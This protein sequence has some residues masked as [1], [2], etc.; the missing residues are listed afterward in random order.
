MYQESGTEPQ[1]GEQFLKIALPADAWSLT[2]VI[3]TK[4]GVHRMSF[5]RWGRFYSQDDSIQHETS[6]LIQRSEC[7]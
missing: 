4:K 3:K 7:H 2:T 1:V 6:T 5:D